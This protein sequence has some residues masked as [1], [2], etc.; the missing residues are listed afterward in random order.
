MPKELA[1][2][3]ALFTVRGFKRGRVLEDVIERLGSADQSENSPEA[4]QAKLAELTQQNQVLNQQLQEGQQ[5]VGELQKKAEGKEMEV[6]S[7]MVIDRE[8]IASEERRHEKDIQA[9][10][11]LGEM[12]IQAKQQGEAAK[13]QAQAEP[14]AEAEN[15]DPIAEVKE[16]IDVIAQAMTQVLDRLDQLTQ[17]VTEEK[18]PKPVTVK[19]GSDGKVAAINDRPVVRDEAGR[20]AGL[21]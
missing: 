20:L 17:F 10:V 11:Y 14:K 21:N 3:L 12:G 9:Q 4:L 18:P 5:I 15:A 7:R 1:K 19:R 8:K 6:Q 16:D 13:L 2:E